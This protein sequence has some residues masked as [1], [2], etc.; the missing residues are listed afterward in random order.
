MSLQLHMCYT[1]VD[2]LDSACSL[3][4][5]HDIRGAVGRPTCQTNICCNLQGD[6]AAKQ[7]MKAL[8]AQKAA[9]VAAQ[10]KQ[11]EAQR[12][13]LAKQVSTAPY[14]CFQPNGFML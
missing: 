3:I 11:A 1:A 9:A 7:Q 5:Q 6:L 13:A 12:A 10:A 8:R 14:S 4:A 2:R